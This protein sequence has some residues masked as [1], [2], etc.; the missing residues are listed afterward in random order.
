MSYPLVSHLPISEQRRIKV[1][2]NVANAFGQT[3]VSRHIVEVYPAK[4]EMNNFWRLGLNLIVD[5]IWFVDLPEGENHYFYGDIGEAE[6]KEIG[7]SETKTVI[8]AILGQ[9]DKSGN[10]VRRLQDLDEENLKKAIG[11]L[12]EHGYKCESILVNIKDVMSLWLKG[13]KH[14]EGIRDRAKNLFGLEGYYADIP[15]YWSNYMPD[16]TTLLIN[17]KSGRFLIKKDIRADVLEIKKEEV[18]DVLK[19]FPELEPEKLG[20][21]VRLRVDEVIRFD[22]GPK[23]AA[24]A[25]KSQ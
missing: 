6:G 1:I 3:A 9:T 7:L 8:N 12:R 16:G 20:E 24:F 18:P 17:K 4:D 5:K 15:I 21:K 11:L 25:L 13:F 14:F 23:D 22:L 19:S 2:E 10:I